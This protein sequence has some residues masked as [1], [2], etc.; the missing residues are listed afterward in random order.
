MRTAQVGFHQVEI[1]QVLRVVVMQLTKNLLEI[2]VGPEMV[3][4]W[5]WLN[6]LAICQEEFGQPY[7][8][9]NPLM[10]SEGPR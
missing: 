4:S 9:K 6:S 2:S 1:T 5:L 3:L 7:G 10:R 8:V